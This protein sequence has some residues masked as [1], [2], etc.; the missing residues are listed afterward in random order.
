MEQRNVK[1]LVC[2]IGN[3]LRGDDG[4]GP[5]TVEYLMKEIEDKNI[6]FL[7]CESSPEN[8]LGVIERMRP[9]KLIIID[10]V[11]FG[12]PP[13]TVEKIDIHTVKKFVSFTHKMPITLFLNYL[14]KKINFR[15]V[16]IGVQPKHLSFGKYMS[17]EC[18][19]AVKK[20][21]EIVKKELI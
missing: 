15:I 14:R 1:T 16:F 10:A 3:R 21:K 18:K 13:G 5:V 8:F 7:S 6:E 4:I 11:D 20:I 17:S 9:E 2:G 19:R 12:K